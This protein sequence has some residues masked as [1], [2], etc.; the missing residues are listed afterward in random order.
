MSAAPQYEFTNEQNALIGSLA[1]KMRFVGLFLFAL[2]ALNILLGVLVLLAIYRSRVPQSWLDQLPQAMKN[3]EGGPVQLTL[4]PNNQLWGIVINAGVVGLFYLLMGSWTRSA[5][6]DF[7]KIVDTQGRDISH[8]MNAL[9][10]LHS[11][12]ALVY[13]LVMVTL[14]I[15]LVAL[16]ICLYLGYMGGA[17]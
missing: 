15:S 13:T 5:A 3:A 14:L 4:P 2:G 7:Q 8:L 16:G 9:A 6:E 12:Y 1:S 11:M 17:G 10:S